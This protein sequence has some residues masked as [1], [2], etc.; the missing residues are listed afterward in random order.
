MVVSVVVFLVV[1]VDFFDFFLVFFG[2]V[3]VLEVDFV[4]VVVLDLS[5]AANEPRLM[6][7]PNT[8]MIIKDINF[9][10]ELSPCR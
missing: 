6:V 5:S 8:A 2:F 9:F 4:V 3:S 1:L 10:M 7:R